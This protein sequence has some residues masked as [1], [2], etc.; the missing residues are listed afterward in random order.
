MTQMNKMQKNKIGAISIILSKSSTRPLHCVLTYLRI[1]K[2][3]KKGL[4]FISLRT[5]TFLSFSVSCENNGSHGLTS[6]ASGISARNEAAVITSEAG[7]R[8]LAVTS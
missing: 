1:R 7:Q 4:G 2:G 8:R 6:G 5:R 3:N